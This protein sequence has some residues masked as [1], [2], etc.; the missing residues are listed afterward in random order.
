APALAEIRFGPQRTKVLRQA[1][2]VT[3]YARSA[4]SQLPGASRQ[5]CEPPKRAALRQ[6][7]FD[8]FIHCGEFMGRDAVRNL[9][10]VL[11]QQ[12]LGFVPYDVRFTN[13]LRQILPKL[14]I[15]TAS[16]SGLDNFSLPG[17]QS[18]AFIADVVQQAVQVVEDAKLGNFRLRC[19]VALPVTLDVIC[20]LRN[21]RETGSASC[22]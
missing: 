16:M 4:D 8:L 18:R 17:G 19:P 11:E 9:R 2:S 10:I 22:R 6:M 15:A 1:R 3:V 7:S 5:Q 20:R 12:R 21:P 13:L 14:Y